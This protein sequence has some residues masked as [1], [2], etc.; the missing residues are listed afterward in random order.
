MGSMAANNH[1]QETIISDSSIRAR[2]ANRFRDA[3]GQETYQLFLPRDH[4]SLL[5]DRNKVE[6]T[7]KE[8]LTNPED[9]VKLTEY[10]VGNAK[11]VFLLLIYSDTIKY[12]GD[13]QKAA[14][15][16][17]DLPVID[18]QSEDGDGVSIHRW[19]VNDTND[20]NDTKREEQA[21][22][23]VG[24]QVLTCFKG[25]RES[26]LEDFV[27]K[28]W[29]FLA[30]VFPSDKFDHVFHDMC[31]LPYVSAQ[32]SGKYSG[33]GHFGTIRRC[34]LYKE[35]QDLF[36]D[37]GVELYIKVAVKK[38]NESDS[39]GTMVD[40]F[41]DKERKTLDK[42]RKLEHPHLIKAIAAYKKGHDRYFVFP[43][44]QGDSLRDLWGSDV[45]LD[46]DLVSWA[47]DQ[48]AGLSDGLKQLHE[49]NTRHG[50]L[51]PENILCFISG[52]QSPHQGTLVLADVG[53][54][55]FHPAYT[56]D[57]TKYTTTRHG[58]KIYEP[59]E[60]FINHGKLKVS[61]RYDVWSLGC[62]F[63]EFTIWLLYGQRG[64]FSFRNTLFKEK[65]ADGFW[66]NEAAEQIQI[67]P[68]AGAW[69]DHILNKDLK[70]DSPLRALVELIITKL[71]VPD[72]QERATTQILYN[73]LVKIQRKEG[74]FNP[75]LRE[76]A[77]HRTGPDVNAKDYTPNLS[78]EYVTSSRLKE[79]ESNRQLILTEAANTAQSH[80]SLLHDQW[81]N[82]TDNKSARTIISR[83]DWPYLQPKTE[84]SFVCDSCA[85]LDFELPTF[86]L[87]R[88]IEELGSSSSECSVCHFLF[89]CLSKV[90][91]KPKGPVK[92]FR[93]D[94]SHTIRVFQCDTP[95]ISIYSD[96][97]QRDNAPSYAQLG[98]PILPNCASPQQFKL[99]NEWIHLCDATHSCVSAREHEAHNDSMPTRVIYV[100]TIDRPSLRLVETGDCIRGK[101]IALSHCWGNLKEGE[102]FVT[103]ASNL[104]NR[105]KGIPLDEM[106]KSF[107]DAVRVSR[108]LG[109]SYLWIDSLCIIQDDGADWE[110]ESAKMEEVFSSA[111][112]TIAASSAKSSLEGFLGNR[113]PRACVTMHT[114][115]GSLLYLT[116][117]IDDFQAHV[118]QSILNS[119]GWVLQ[120]RTLS[121]R[122]IHF[123]ST[124]VYWECG[125]GIYC[126]TL[127]QLLNPQS[128]FLGD[129]SFPN[130]GLQYYK[131]ERIRLVQHLYQVYCALQLT[132]VT[133]RSKAIL[134]LEKR[135]SRTFKSRAD[136]GLV[137]GYFERTILWQAKTSNSLSPIPYG[138]R[139]VVPSW[140]WM[141]CTGEIQYMDIPFGQVDWTGNLTNPTGS[142]PEDVEWD[143]QLTAEHVQV[144]L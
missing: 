72:T 103:S 137:W 122:T 48:M 31:R 20:T 120:E 135:L 28:Q 13:L 83:L 29:I 134:G 57:R 79:C 27:E 26:E 139:R 63:L 12:I 73:E 4:I 101:Y 65:M 81:R 121:R 41:Y 2:C 21:L 23:Y 64:L 80:T 14:F 1:R 49:K 98:L 30:P 110:V 33:Q 133:D 42:M 52:D 74:L 68:V 18:T 32:G 9:V 128:Q 138:D 84:T 44:A 82:V 109:I 86:D 47:I 112:C 15:T 96:P 123:T 10:V 37:K 11:K 67:H 94:A 22:T 104:D 61:R 111:Y 102:R 34:G 43:W 107:Q 69:V 132:N 62:V 131:D 75:E 7:L 38:L 76:L 71:L 87:Y 85:A 108:A 60:M 19:H 56:R 130:L 45:K 116:E 106:P 95:I 54:A 35:H 39:P 46:K 141:A 70:L 114:S 142:V 89:Y 136:Y 99:L 17:D 97:V 115:Q 40:K 90:K 113:T 119:R 51:K 50:D 125:R 25:W 93:D 3:G 78:Q 77:K 143:G 144:R 36:K 8:K 126:E 53:L 24:E 140:S 6:L 88:S 59:P 16:D 58:T 127:A 66:S 118:E 124:Q 92:L 5:T 55:K 105:K 117:A 100:G 129:P 91:P